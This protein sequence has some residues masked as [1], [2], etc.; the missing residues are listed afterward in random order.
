MKLKI[1]NKKRVVVVGQQ[2]FQ[3]ASA[4]DLA[5][6]EKYT[7]IGYTVEVREPKKVKGDKTTDAEMRAQLSGKELATYEDLK[8]QSFFKAKRYFKSLNK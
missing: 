2:A 3:K 6:L 7:A 5:A 1:D 4:E 8:A